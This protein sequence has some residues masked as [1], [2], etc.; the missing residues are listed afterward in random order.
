[1]TRISGI[2]VSQFQGDIHWPTV[3]QTQSFAILRAYRGGPRRPDTRFHEYATGATA[4]GLP[5]SGYAFA[6]PTWSA[7]D[8][9]D[10]FLDVVSGYPNTMPH[11]LDL[12]T[13]PTRPSHSRDNLT[14]RQRTDWALEWLERVEAVTGNRPMIY[15][16]GLYPR[17]LLIDTD[18]RLARY[19][20]WVAWYGRSTPPP[21]PQPWSE[22]SIWQW[23]DDRK[24]AG[25]QSASCDLNWTTQETLDA[26]M[27]PYLPEPAKPVKADADP[28]VTRLLARIEANAGRLD[29]QL[30]TADRDQLQVYVDRIQANTARLR[31]RLG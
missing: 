5:W 11:V 12:E 4:A 18:Q 15:C 24:V 19:R 7:V 1:M 14:R 8:Q 16:S 22:W 21:A 30:G 28:D 9:A 26:L 6:M 3:K 29:R 25:V 27:A 13:G 17:E 10:A 31:K 20:L 23:S 2:D